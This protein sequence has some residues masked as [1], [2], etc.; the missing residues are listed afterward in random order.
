[1]PKG[2][3]GLR[4][5]SSLTKQEGVVKNGVQSSRIRKSK[6]T[7]AANELTERRGGRGETIAHHKGR[8]GQQGWD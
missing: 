6:S 3:V 1:V 2:L 5:P 4:K 7:Y 8:G